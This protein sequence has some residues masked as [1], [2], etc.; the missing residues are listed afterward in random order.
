[1]SC[2]FSVRFFVMNCGGLCI[3]G[4]LCQRKHSYSYSYSVDDQDEEGDEKSGE[5]EADVEPDITFGDFDQDVAYSYSHQDIIFGDF[6]AQP[7]SLEH[8]VSC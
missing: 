3:F 7:L 4:L 6:P 2:N 1:M 5:N 8:E